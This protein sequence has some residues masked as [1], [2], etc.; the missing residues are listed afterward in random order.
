MANFASSP[1]RDN[2]V[3][4]WKNIV[5]SFLFMFSVIASLGVMFITQ[6]ATAQI[7]GGKCTNFVLLGDHQGVGDKEGG[8]ED[9]LK[10]KTGSKTFRGDVNNDRDI[11][12]ITR[13]ARSTNLRETCVIIEA[14]TKDSHRSNSEDNIKS[15]LEEAM[16]VL[17][18]AQ[19]VFWVTPVVDDESKGNQYPTKRFADAL[20]ETKN[21]NVSIINIQELSRNS[22]LFRESGSGAGVS[23]TEQGYKKRVDLI[24]KQIA[25]INNPNESPSSSPSSSSS[26]PS[27]PPPTTTSG[28]GVPTTS[29]TAP[30]QRTL[31]PGSG[32]NAGNSET[33]DPGVIECDP[34]KKNDC[35]KLD[36]SLSSPKSYSDKIK[37]VT[38]ISEARDY[39]IINRWSEFSIPKP[40]MSI[41]T[42][43]SFIHVIYSSFGEMFLS[44]SQTIA[45][46]VISATIFV[47]SDVAA[48]WVVSM[49]DKIL[50]SLVANVGMTSITIIAGS[51][52]SIAFIFAFVDVLNT[53]GGF[54]VK[55]KVASVA[56]A[57]GKTILSIFFVV[58]VASQ[59]AKNSSQHAAAD[60]KGDPI[61]AGSD[62]ALNSSK[63]LNVGDF[64]TWEPLSL[65]WFMAL[66]VD[67]GQDVAGAM[68]TIGSTLALKPLE[69]MSQSLSGKKYDQNASCERFIDGIN[70]GFSN[71]EAVKQKP[72]MGS[73]LS[74]ID[75]FYV[76]YQIRSYALIY[77]GQTLEGS[78]SY[79]WQLENGAQ[80][81][82]GETF[83]FAR[84]AGI[85]KEMVGGGNIIDGNSTK[86]TSGKHYA[87]DYRQNLSTEG[88]GLPIGGG[89]LVDKEGNWADATDTFAPQQRGQRYLMGSGDG[90]SQAKYY[91]SACVWR[92]QDK[93]ATISQSWAGIQA[94]GA[95]GEFPERDGQQP[96]R[97]VEDYSLS[98]EDIARRTAVKAQFDKDYFGKA[99]YDAEAREVL[100]NGYMNE[101]VKD[102]VEVSIPSPMT[103]KM[104][105]ADCV[106]NMLFPLDSLKTDSLTGWGSYN[107][108]VQRW[109]YDPL[110]PP[111]LSDA[112][113][114]VV[115]SNPAV[116]LV[117]GVVGAIG[118]AGDA[119]E[120]AGEAETLPNPEKEPD[121][122]PRFHGRENKD[123]GFNEPLKFW[124]NSN[125][126][127]KPT[128]KT[129]F[130]G[131]SVVISALLF[132]FAFPFLLI[133]A[134]VNVMF[135]LYLFLAGMAMV[136]TII[137]YAF[138]GVKR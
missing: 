17:R 13:W 1:W 125:G 100:D 23:M 104:V 39:L 21:D 72:A 86:W 114:S 109:N 89:Y 127:G 120:N 63:E 94:M 45:S 129:G 69:G 71:T 5:V 137:M 106:N 61:S 99:G 32:S 20:N 43:S 136:G 55:N 126:Y 53:R 108:W 79:C 124:Q 75:F 10:D 122:R 59:S 26:S 96:P 98:D 138:K 42:P 123:T 70:Q 92:P 74:T 78:N 128:D 112:I 50:A 107:Q 30:G 95:S 41:T 66:G 14:G 33:G 47:T 65:G 117:T 54:N 102:S 135:I 35:D 67:L 34:A 93:T 64:T 134:L 97:V 7:Q 27:S 19:H 113:K 87:S 38:N 133:L 130:S 60:Q 110:P 46:I 2:S 40:P 81:P 57:T 3:T 90:F 105:Q 85:Y 44:L 80:R 58:F 73:M 16:R 83:L 18:G 49:A 76:K 68:Y 131:L 24:V 12:Q 22:K 29:S 115:T 103:N 111:P 9:A 11:K 56:A 77:G 36:N 52:A 119:I 116:G 82:V 15:D 31:P 51:L 37:K 132:L 88:G 25:S 4:R 121:P 8:I 84:S 101:G 6:D 91:F 118:D 28:A 62:A 48:T